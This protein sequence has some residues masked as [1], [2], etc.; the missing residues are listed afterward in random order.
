LIVSADQILP[1]FVVNEMPAGFA[2][3]LIAAIVAASMSSMSSGINSV[4]TVALVDLYGQYSKKELGERKKVSIARMITVVF[5][6]VVT[7]IAFSAKRF[8]TLIEAPVRIF[9]LL[10]G[11]LLGLF[12]LG[13]LCERANSRGAITGWIFGTIMTMFVVF[14][15][16]FT[17]LWYAITGAVSTYITGWAVSFIWPKPPVEKIQGFTWRSRF[18]TENE[19]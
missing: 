5:G 10:G 13:M 7:L 12:L 11:P 14:A 9:G 2:G 16:D 18:E 8:G 4:T 6:I 3:V 19:E 15:T 17:F 1:Y